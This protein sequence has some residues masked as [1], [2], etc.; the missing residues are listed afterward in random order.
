M[1]RI[2]VYLPLLILVALLS[3]AGGFIYG[4]Y[5]ERED[6]LAKENTDPEAFV[7]QNLVASN[8]NAQAQP[9]QNES[10]VILPADLAKAK[11][12]PEKIANAQGEY[13]LVSV[14]EGAQVNQQ[15]SDNLRLVTAQRQQLGT[16]AQQFQKTPQ[17]AVQQRELLAGEINQVKMSLQRNLVAMARSYSYTLSNTYLR[18]PHVVTLLSVEKKDEKFETEAVHKFESADDYLAFQ[19]KNDSYQRMK[20]EHVQAEEVAEQSKTKAKGQTAAKPSDEQEATLVA[21]EEADSH[22][23][24]DTPAEIELTEKLVKQ[25]AALRAMQAEMVKEYHFDPEEQHLLQFEKTA[26]YARPVQ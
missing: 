20:L 21:G 13:T 23:V 11:N 12:V 17:D 19:K 8:G 1:K 7:Q 18:I 14:V 10:N 9:Q 25:T 3:S 15:L 6:K 22:P 16:L 2:I 4:R 24:A 5:Y 26:L